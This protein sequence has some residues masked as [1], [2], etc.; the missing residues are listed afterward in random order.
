MKRANLLLTGAIALGLG[1]LTSCGGATNE[2]EAKAAAE[3]MAAE[4]TEGLEDAAKEIEVE[5]PEANDSTATD[6][7]EAP[8]A[9]DST[10]TDAVEPAEG[11]ATED[12]AT[13]A[14]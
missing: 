12:E 11:E 2:A 13:P 7:V 6:A 3:K 9:N 14:E 5:T 4:L 1:V 8:E 10:A